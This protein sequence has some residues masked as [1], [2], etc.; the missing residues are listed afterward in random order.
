MCGG[1]RFFI[2]ICK[3]NLLISP[4]INEEKERTRGRGI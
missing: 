2:V 4:R 1:K 3:V